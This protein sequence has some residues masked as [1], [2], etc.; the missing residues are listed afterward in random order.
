MV[1]RQEE[2]RACKNSL[3]READG[4]RHRGQMADEI[5]CEVRDKPRKVQFLELQ[6]PRNLDLGS[7]PDHISMHSTYDTIS[8]LD[9]VT[10]TSSNTETWPVE[11][12][13]I[14]TFRDV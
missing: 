2:H 10:L 1:G 6:N 7:G 4:H 8:T 5:N 11:F 9:H 13:I 12:R 3:G 14:W